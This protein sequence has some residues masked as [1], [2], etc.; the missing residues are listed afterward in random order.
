MEDATPAAYRLADSTSVY[1]RLHA[2]QPVAWWPW[3]DAALAEARVRDVPVLLSVGYATCHWCHVMARESFDDPE[4]GALM[5]ENFV[6][7]KVDREARPDVDAVYMAALQMLTGS[8]GWPMTLAL[9]PD[10]RPWYAGT[11][12]PPDDR[13]GRPSFRR[14]L[15]ALSHAWRERRDEV[16]RSADEIAAALARLE[17]GAPVAGTAKAAAVGDAATA[18]MTGA[19]QVAPAPDTRPSARLAEAEPLVLQALQATYDAGRGGFGDAP[20]F[21]PHAAL[22]WLELVPGEAADAMRHRT[23]RAIVDGGVTDQLGGALHRYAVD[24]GWAV[25]HFEVM[26]VDQAQMLPRLA[27]AAAETGDARLA[28]GATA[29]LDALERDL[30]RDDA[31]FATGLDAEAGGVEGSFHTWTPEE[32]ARALPAGDDAEVAARLFGV[33]PVGPLEGRSVLAWNGHDGGGLGEAGADRVASLRARLL[34]ARAERPRPR[35]DDPAIT[36]Y[37]GLML[38]GLVEAADHLPASAAARAGALA[39]EAADALWARAWDG[40]RLRRLVDA[41]AADPEHGVAL[42]DDQVHA[43]LACFALHRATGDRRHLARALDLAAVVAEDFALPGGGFATVPRDADVPLVRARDGLDGA[44]PA[45]EPAAALLLAHAAAWTEREDWRAAAEGALA[46]VAALARTAPSAAVSALIAARALRRPPNQVVVVGPADDARTAALLAAARAHPGEPCV[47]RSDGPDD[48]WTERIPWLAG[49]GAV[50]GLPTAYACT[51][52]V[53][54]LPVHAPDDLVREIA[55]LDAARTLDGDAGREAAH[56]DG[57][58]PQAD[59]AA[60]G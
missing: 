11:Y 7:I 14:V 17:G 24:G 55:A 56:H 36:A 42:L 35:R 18:T 57:S 46:G 32:L 12:F 58:G 13:F 22:R 3:G 4:V 52:G 60:D 19:V 16:E 41:P 51:A 26:L 20:K 44:T 23:L 53:C 59:A 6:S 45:A 48:P 21:P 31:L 33:A 15:A 25:P 49:R 9:T 10:G 5:N 39:L 27:R 40:R 38:R 8:G 54:R 2:H 43:G 30:L 29:M 28:W 34:R 47:L 50:D 37:V 1:L